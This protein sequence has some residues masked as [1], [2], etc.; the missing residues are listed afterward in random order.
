MVHDGTGTGLQLLR[1]RRS[2]RFVSEG[3]TLG[4]TVFPAVPRNPLLQT[5]PGYFKDPLIFLTSP[6]LGKTR[7]CQA[8]RHAARVSQ[9]VR[10]HRWSGFLGRVTGIFLSLVHDSSP[11]FCSYAAP[12]SL[13]YKALQSNF[14]TY[15]PVRFYPT[16]CVIHSLKYISGIMTALLLI[17]LIFFEKK[18]V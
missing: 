8:F 15:A 18:A 11:V 9:G 13:Q 17:S 3:R 7:R 4:T 12:S 16:S 14:S 2:H 5:P 6:R 1:E 10:N